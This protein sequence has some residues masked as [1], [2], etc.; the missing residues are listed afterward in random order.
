M[1]IIQGGVVQPG[2]EQ[3]VVIEEIL[4]TET[5]GAGVYTGSVAVPAGAY[6]LDVIVHGTAVWDAA[7]SA[8]L[9]VGDGVDDDGLFAGVD[10]K[11]TDLLAAEGLSLSGGAGLAGGKQGADIANSQ[12]NRRW[13]ATARTISAVVTTVGASGSAGRTRVIVAYIVPQITKNAVKA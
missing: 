9:K 8:T 10:L 5:T 1:P 11:S 13:L 12:W 3:R 2:A 7:T 4:F 6:L